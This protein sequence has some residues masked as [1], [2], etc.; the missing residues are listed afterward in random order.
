MYVNP[1][2]SWRRS[3][4]NISQKFHRRLEKNYA[5]DVINSLEILKIY[6]PLNENKNY[7]YFFSN[8]HLRFH[9]KFFE[10]KIFTQLKNIFIL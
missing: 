7:I 9:Y 1:F 5:R 8:P 3:K 10:T 2:H 4:K 6:H